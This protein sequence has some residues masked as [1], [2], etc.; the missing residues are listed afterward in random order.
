MGASQ[1]V[2]LVPGNILEMTNKLANLEATTIFGLFFFGLFV[3]RATPLGAIFG[4][5]FGLTASVL[6]AFW[7]VLIGQPAISFLYIAQFVVPASAGFGGCASR[8]K[9]E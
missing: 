5:V 7:D 9:A 3:P 1:L 2:R 8:L 4:A 6:V